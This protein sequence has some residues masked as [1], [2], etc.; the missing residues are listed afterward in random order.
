MVFFER[1]G[2]SRL[3]LAVM[4]PFVT[5][6]AI[7]AVTVS[8][9]EYQKFTRESSRISLEIHSAIDRSFKGAVAS[10]TASLRAVAEAL[11]TNDGLKVALRQRDR[12]RLMRIA[13]PMLA[14]LGHSAS[15]SHLY[16]IDA[17]QTAVLRVHQP[18]RYGD[19]IDRITTRTA[20]QTRAAAAGIELGPLGTMTLRVVVPWFDNGELIGFVETGKE[21]DHLFEALR[22]QFDLHALVFIPKAR[23]DRQ[24]WEA[25][26]AMLGRPFDW[27]E[28]PDQVLSIR[29]G[30]SPVVIRQFLAGH[31]G[32]LNVGDGWYSWLRLDVPDA[33]GGNAAMVGLVMDIT[34]RHQELVRFGLLLAGIALG[35]SVVVIALFWLIID[36]VEAELMRARRRSELLLSSAGE[37]IIGVDLAGR[38]IF[39]N[40]AA[41]DM[42]GFASLADMIGQDVHF[43]TGHCHGDGSPCDAG[44]CAVRMTLGDGIRRRVDQD[45]YQH[46]GGGRFPVEFSVTAM[47]DNGRITGVVLVFHDISERSAAE[48]ALADAAGRMEAQ[49]REVARINAELEQFAYVASHDLRQPLRMVSSYLGLIERKLGPQLDD[50]LKTCFGFAMGGAQR[51]DRLILDLLEYSRTGRSAEPAVPVP[52]LEAVADSLVN[53]EVA[54]GEAGAQVTVAEGLPT[55][56]GDRAELTRLFQNLIGNAVKYRATDRRP[57]IE[58]GHRRDGDEVVVWVRDNGIGLSPN[59]H[60]RAFQIFQRAVRN[61]QYE[62]SGIGLAICKKIIDNCGGRIWIESAEG[63]GC[64]FYLAFPIIRAVA[65]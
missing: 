44:E 32:E 20:R 55:I 6:V 57:E 2:I 58:I 5:F 7:L 46:N 41:Q 19:V 54:I 40:P 63:Q 36:R 48:R 60:Q 29:N 31:R 27:D 52:L 38:C 28:F 59:D 62:G 9:I 21:I 34:V 12:Q 16:F 25:G 13:G 18:E 64:C 53:L 50:D 1:M 45:L 43:L 15:I 56:S 10:E 35:G 33:G 51:M 22:Q 11:A 24:G 14:N 39:A 8:V 23:L 61:D 3:K 30:I 17:E 49:S 26:M 47:A 65:A 42:L 37:G 4:V